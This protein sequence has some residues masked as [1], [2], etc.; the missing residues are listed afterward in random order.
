[1]SAGTIFIE[2]DLDSTKYKSKMAEIQATANKS[3][4]ALESNFMR[5]GGKSDQMYQAMRQGATNAYNMI[6]NSAKSSTSERLRAHRLYTEQIKKLDDEQAGRMTKN[7]GAIKIGWLTMVK[8]AIVFRTAMAAIHGLY[9]ATIGSLKRGIQSIDDMKLAQASLASAFATNDIS[10]TFEKANRIAGGMV[11]KIQEMDRAFVGTAQEL[12]VLVDAM[13]TYGAGV[14]LSNKNAQQQ[15]VQF[16]NIIKLMT[17]GQDFQRQAMQEV[18]A[19]MEGANVQGALLVKKLTAMGVNV[20]TMIP[21][22][23]EQGTLVQNITKLLSGYEKGTK[24]IEKTLEAQKSSLSTIADKILRQA[25]S[26]AYTEIVGLVKEINDSLLDAHGLTEKAKTIAVALGVAWETVS[27]TVKTVGYLIKTL[28]T[29][30]IRDAKR[31]TEEFNEAIDNIKRGA[32]QASPISGDV[33]TDLVGDADEWEGQG[34]ENARAYLRGLGIISGTATEGML[35]L[36]EERDRYFSDLLKTMGAKGKGK[37]KDDKEA[38]RAAKRLEKAWIGALGAMSVSYDDYV[39]SVESAALE[40]TNYMIDLDKKMFAERAKLIQNDLGNWL[41]WQKAET[42]ALVE[43]ALR[44]QKVW[45]EA[46]KKQMEY[47]EQFRDWVIHG[48]EQMAD[49]VAEFVTTG[50]ASF[51][52]FVNSAVA[53]LARLITKMSIF[54]ILGGLGFGDYLQIGA[55]AAG[56][57]VA[58]ATPYLVG[59][60]GP[61]LFVPSSA[62]TIVPNTGP[63]N[64]TVNIRNESGQKMEATQARASFDARGMIL[65][66][67]IDGINRNVR[68]MRDMMGGGR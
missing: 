47:A 27:A 26:G 3:S 4:L 64:V 51:K 55:R 24:E 46:Q 22:W 15:F 43:E 50:K 59:E 30:R 38:E 1:M 35:S 18:R 42:D 52:D 25:M 29:D 57:P 10:L 44:Q 61:E 28:I 56:G 34:R 32:T 62:G 40:Y 7:L 37:G 21:L 66:V 17:R 33:I 68:G 9:E 54:K 49:V 63:K 8:G 31:I 16:A 19:L 48:F 6:T 53:D 67:V 45:E 58:A 20:K 60:R 14:D 65:D 11:E 12:T 5:L 36:E 41:E 23:R 2:L 39:E 13:A